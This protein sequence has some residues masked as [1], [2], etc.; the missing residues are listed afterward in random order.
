MD[1]CKNVDFDQLSE[2]EIVENLNDNSWVVNHTNCW[3]GEF[4]KQIL[5][6]S[7]L[8]SLPPDFPL[9]KDLNSSKLSNQ[10]SYID[11]Y[12]TLRKDKGKLEFVF[13]HL[14]SLFIAAGF[15]GAYVLV[16]D[17]EKIPDFQSSNQ[18]KD[19]ATQLRTVLFDG[20]YLNAKIGFYNFILA[21]HAGVPRLMQ[22]PWSLAGMEQRVPMSSSSVDQ[23]HIVNFGKLENKHALTLIKKYLSEF[24]KAGFDGDELHPFTEQG[25]ITLA[26]QSEMNISKI[27]KN[28]N[29]IIE[30]ADSENVQSID[31]EFVKKYFSK[32]SATQDSAEEKLATQSE[33]VDLM[34]K[35]QSD[36]KK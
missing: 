15:N 17:F 16:D 4:T 6:K 30:L 32:K 33:T 24:R 3:K 12:N 31:D 10:F 1:A 35:I 18:K 8:S 19:F 20:G 5:K 23:K 26:N 34:Q 7:W 13:D 2:S 25:I 14:V 21:L 22:E 11:Y 27:L 36:D 28:S 9:Y 29:Q